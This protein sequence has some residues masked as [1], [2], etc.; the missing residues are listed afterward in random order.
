MHDTHEPLLLVSVLRLCQLVFIH[1]RTCTLLV[2]SMH[3]YFT[4]VVRV[5]LSLSFRLVVCVCVCARVYV[6]LIHMISLLCLSNTYRV[7]V[8]LK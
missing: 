7:C 8:M 2:F 5:L 1:S 6:K 4:H 3:A